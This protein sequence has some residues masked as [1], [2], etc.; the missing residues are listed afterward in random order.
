MIKAI[1][2]NFEGIK[3][4]NL[5]LSGGVSSE[6]IAFA[7]LELSILLEGGLNLLKALEVVSSQTGNKRLRDALLSVKSAVEGGQSL[8]GAFLKSNVF[9]EFF[10][11]MLRTAE[12]G[13][14]LSQVLRISGE[15]LQKLSE[16]R[17]KV[18]TS[19]AYPSFVIF[20]SILSVLV[21]VKVVV[22]KITAVLQ[23]LGKELPLIT[24]A[25]MVFS[26]VISYSL[27]L[28]PVLALLYIFRHKL[29]RRESWDAY[30]LK[31]PVFG[32]VS[33][34][35]NLSRFAGTLLMSLSS[36]IP[37]TRALSLS[38]GSITN[39]YL[40]SSLKGV[41]EEVA[42]G[43]SI[44]S[45]L[46]DRKVLPETFT[47][48]LLVGEKSGE[49]EKSLKMLQSMYE[50]QAER[51]VGFWLRFAEPIAMLLVAFLVAVVVLSVVLPLSEISAG[52][53]K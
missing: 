48:L 34:Y 42:K 43:R 8:Y 13:E 16:T 25:I 10:L 51:V 1:P 24:R 3:V 35:Y 2:I 23:G 47:N 12:R 33:Y 52:V 39:A 37:I 27:Y 6:E 53:K 30:M 20:A 18:L 9:P 44:S 14:N 22:P 50:R 40:R 21:V 41:K 36:G 31:V 17:S 15:Y 45:A 29:I 49:L 4:L 38:V 19:L 26:E 7:L 46:R 11:E 32:K 5:R 28:L